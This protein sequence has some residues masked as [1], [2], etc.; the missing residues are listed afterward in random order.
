MTNKDKIFINCDDL[1]NIP[2]LHR[3][4]YFFEHDYL[5]K[6]LKYN[7]SVLQVG[8]MDGLRAD[9]L[10]SARPDLEFT[11]L[12][13]EENLVEIARKH[14]AES[15]K[16]AKFIHG[17]ICN[18]PASLKQYEYVLCLNNTLGFITD[19]TAALNQMK[20]HGRSIVVSVYGEDF[21]EKLAS[22]YF[23]SIGLE[24]LK[25]DEGRFMLKDFS[26]VPRFTKKD[27]A[28]WGGSVTKTPIGYICTISR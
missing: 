23:S 7:A 19:T 14:T 13:I 9:R 27:V 28:L 17:D 20:K 21:D 22:E 8:S 24:F 3:Q 6:T 16:K 1:D 2:A 5:V 18:P 25:A 15:H 12:E 26:Y 11:G 4:N 10:L